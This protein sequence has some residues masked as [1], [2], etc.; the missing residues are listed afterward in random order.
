MHGHSEQSEAELKKPTEVIVK[1]S[2]RDPSVQAGLA[3]SLGMTEEVCY[4]SES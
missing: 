4:G 3:F 1:L 2:Q